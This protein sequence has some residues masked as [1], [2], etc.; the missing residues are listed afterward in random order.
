MQ[1]YEVNTVIE[2][3]PYL[4]R[5]MWEQHRFLIYTNIQMNSKKKLNPSDILKFKWDEDYKD[6]STSITT[7]EIERLR[8][9]SQHII[10]SINNE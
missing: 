2:N 10:R 1:E 8:N 3:L 6:D 9:K 4:D 7:Q 5:N